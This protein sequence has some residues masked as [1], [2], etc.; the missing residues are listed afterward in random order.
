[1]P[2]QPSRITGMVLCQNYLKPRD[3]LPNSKR[4]SKA[5]MQHID[6]IVGKVRHYIVARSE[7]SAQTCVLVTPSVLLFG[8]IYPITWKLLA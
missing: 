1:M 2:I 3:Y 7:T 6:V 4:P 8:V 5:T